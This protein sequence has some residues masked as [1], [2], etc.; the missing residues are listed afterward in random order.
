[1][2]TVELRAAYADHQRRAARSTTSIGAIVA[3]VA[4]PAWAIFDEL[5]LPARAASFL[6]VRILF[7]IAILLAL[8][9][10]RSQRIGGRWPEATSFVMVALPQLAISW[11]IPRSDNRLEP[12]LLGLSLV[13]FASAFLIVWR[14][15]LTVLLV[16]L[17]S[18]QVA[19]A[20]L[21]SPASPPDHEIATIVFYLATAGAIAVAAQLYRHH[22]G[23]KRFVAEAAL[24]AERVRNAA[25][26]EE[27]DQISRE[28]ALTGVGNRRAWE[29]RTVSELLRAARDGGSVSMILCDL[30]NFK[31]VNDTY[32]HA[33]GDRVLRVAAAL[34]TQRARP[35]DFVVR[36]GGDEF[37]VVCPDTDV[38]TAQALALDIAELG[39]ETRWPGGAS[40][41]FSVGVAEARPGDVDPDEVLHRADLALYSA[42]TT[43]DAVRIR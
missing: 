18:L 16:A 25:L 41:T 15:H 22:N 1:V 31:A 39:R 29:Q 8:L 2:T 37:C 12:Y 40:V 33:T 5:V 21:T 26:V 36:L 32:G 42:K 13:I 11:M 24:E 27:L 6:G 4:F 43:R 23:W 10:L 35:T 20:Y 3:L 30:D 34:L 14:W 38:L 19:L 17:T 28:D 9:A 7:E